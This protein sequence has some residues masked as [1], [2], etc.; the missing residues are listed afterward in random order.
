MSQQNNGNQNNNVDKIVT[1][2]VVFKNQA[3]AELLAGAEILAAAVASTM[4]PSGHSVIIDNE[5]GPPT[6]TKDGVTVARSINLKNRLKSI[7]AELLKEVA[8]KTN[9]LAGDGTTTATVLGYALLKEGVKQIATGRSSIHLKRGMDDATGVAIKFLKDNCIPIG[10]KEDIIN[11]GTISAN[12][13]RDLGELIA[14]AIQKVGKDGIVT[15]EPAKSVQ[16]TLDIVEGMQIDKGFISPFFVT[17]SE[18]SSCE[19]DNP[20]ILMTSNKISSIADIMTV[21]EKILKSDRPILIIADEVEGDA[22]H[23]LIVNKMKGVLKVCAIKAPSYGENRADN[24]SDLSMVVGGEVFG[25]S[26][27]AALKNAT[28]DQLG[29]A[30]KVVV[31]RNSCVIV[32]ETSNE[33]RKK[34][35]AERINSLRTSL[36]TDTSLDGLRISKYRERLAKL[37]GG[38]AVIRV[39]GSTEVE[40]KEKKDRVEDAVNA[41]IAASREGIV[42]GGG[43][44]LFYT[45]QMLRSMIRSGQFVDNTGHGDDY[46]AGVKI[47]ADVCE[48]PLKTIV[49]NTGQSAEVVANALMEKYKI[50]PDFRIGYDAAKGVFVDLITAGILDPVL[51][52]R[53]SLEFATSV[54]GLTLTC[55][56]VVVDE[57]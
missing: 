6:I 44:A 13:D 50:N 49:K 3:H 46:M 12:G 28:L 37:S 22:L 8:A 54:I 25:S 57:E 29:Q 14:E 55:D 45:S 26:S 5:F 41:T 53:S 51:V 40:I 48:Y 30:K 24:L 31:T 47:I 1:Q 27:Q 20:Y 42:P 43:T 2:T 15:I 9:D 56:A 11:V 39:G 33:E 38:I 35:I 18:K 16:T 17:N 19:L 21:L 52:T 36:E 32:A 4:G 34:K 23:T 10:S 7:G